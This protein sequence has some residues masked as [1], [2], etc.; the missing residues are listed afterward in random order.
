ML[1]QSEEP[2]VNVQVETIDGKQFIRCSDCN[3]PKPVYDTARIP[4]KLRDRIQQINVRINYLK[5]RLPGRPEV[6]T[7]HFK[8]LTLL[9]K[10]I[11]EAERTQLLRAVPLYRSPIDK[12][13]MICGTCFDNIWSENFN[14]HG[15]RKG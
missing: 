13:R 15:D 12:D 2:S 5:N 4:S 6:L 9:E 7:Q 10:E 11:R 1:Q 3:S 8:E 14:R